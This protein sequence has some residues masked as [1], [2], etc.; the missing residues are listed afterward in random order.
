MKKGFCRLCF[1][2]V[3][4][5]NLHVS[6]CA[7]KSGE[8]RESYRLTR[9]FLPNRGTRGSSGASRRKEEQAAQG[10]RYA[11]L[12]IHTARRHDALVLSKYGPISVHRDHPID[13]DEEREDIER[14]VGDRL[15]MQVLDPGRFRRGLWGW[16][17][18][19]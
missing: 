15:V 8:E 9:M 11:D 1:T 14:E 3:G 6:H 5:L 18:H 2:T 17:R 12:H 10:S 19:G 7:T 4:D 16:G 13:L